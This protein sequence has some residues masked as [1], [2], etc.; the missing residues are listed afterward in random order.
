MKAKS[1]SEIYDI[2]DPQEALSGE[3]LKEFYVRRESPID[4][5]ANALR[6]SGRPLK[7][8]FVGS[9]GNGKSTELNRLSEILEDDLLIV[10]FSIRDKLNL[11]DI[12]YS[13]DFEKP[14]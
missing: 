12:E 14:N 3:T 9:R 4:R 5:H 6:S 8:L 2:F 7:Y 13:E 1:L 11:Y 10:P